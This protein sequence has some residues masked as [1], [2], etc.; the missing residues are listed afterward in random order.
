MLR[1]LLEIARLT[2]RV[3]LELSE[4]DPYRLG[5]EEVEAHSPVTQS[6]ESERNADEIARLMASPTGNDMVEGALRLVVNLAQA[7]VNG[8]D[9]VSVSLLRDGRVMTV[10]ASDQTVREM[11]AHQ[12]ATGEGPCL[13]A[14]LEGP[15]VPR[16]DSRPRDALAGVHYPLARALGILAILS[17]PLLVRDR[18]VGAL[19]IYSRTAV[20]FS[21]REKELAAVYATEVSKILAD[22][23]A[24]IDL[25][26]GALASRLRLA[27]QTRH[28][29]SVAQGVLMERENVGEDAA[30]TLLRRLSEHLGRSLGE[31]ASH[32][33]ASTRRPELG[34]PSAPRCE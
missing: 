25:E 16:R 9:G 33:V 21:T 29:I 24:S 5:R 32:V 28:T 26:T 31:R 19:N 1:R 30:F 11:D 22:T 27:L 13:D 23:D 6:D 3:R 14:S 10:A 8:A 7:T 17:S 4:V 18:P 20:A 15:L 12:Y 2:D 34:S